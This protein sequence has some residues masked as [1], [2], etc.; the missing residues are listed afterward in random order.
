MKGHLLHRSIIVTLVGILTVFVVVMVIPNVRFA[1]QVFNAPPQNSYLPYVRF[2]ELPYQPEDTRGW[3]QEPGENFFKEGMACYARKDYECAVRNLTQAVRLAPDRAHWWLY[4]GVS[5]FVRHEFQPAV[6]ALKNA[7]FL[8][9]RNASLRPYANW[10]LAESY[11][12][13]DRPGDA[14]PLLEMVSAERRD[15]AADADSLLDQVRRLATV[16]AAS[17]K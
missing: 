13:V 1:K 4:L 14:I 15:H 5:H 17:A 9:E 11:L 16:S 3:T 2:G 7:Q 10:Y 8:S 6:A 12:M